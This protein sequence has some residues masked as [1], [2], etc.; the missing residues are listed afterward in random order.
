M[1]LLRTLTGDPRDECLNT[2]WFMSLKHAREVIEEWRQDYNEVR[3][4]SELKRK[5]SKEYA[6]AAA[7]STSR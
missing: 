5:T 6:E 4:H 7:G 1:F 2:N 3:P